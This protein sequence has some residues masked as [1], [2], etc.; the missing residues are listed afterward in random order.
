MCRFHAKT[1][2]DQPIMRVCGVE[3]AWRLDDDSFITRNI[4]YDVF[5]LMQHKQLVYGFVKVYGEEPKWTKGL[6]HAAEQY[7][8]ATALET[9]FFRKWPRNKMYYN[10]FEISRLSFWLSADYQRFI[11]Y[12][13]D[14]GGIYYHRWGDGPIKSIAVAMFVP[15]PQTYHFKD[16][17]Y[18]HQFFRRP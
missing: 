4:S 1:V 9:K 13:D 10:N 17:G 11:E 12:I 2:Y 18:R 16:I 5:E 14:L 7:I 3:F 6:W 15:R 8:N